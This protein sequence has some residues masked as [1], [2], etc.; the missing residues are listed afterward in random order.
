M[1][2]FGTRARI[3]QGVLGIVTV[4][5]HR[6]RD[7]PTLISAEAPAGS[8]DSTATRHGPRRSSSWTR[9]NR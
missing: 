5:I 6:A 4:T 2:G 8:S 1:S 3:D 9:R 7:V